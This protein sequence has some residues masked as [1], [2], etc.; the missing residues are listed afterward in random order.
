MAQ[1][2][3]TFPI[4]DNYGPF[5]QFSQ[6]GPVFFDSQ[7][8][9][10]QLNHSVPMYSPVQHYSEQ[11][12]VP[13]F[14]RHS[15]QSPVI[16][17]SPAQHVDPV[18]EQ[19]HHPYNADCYR[20]THPPPLPD[21]G[22]VSHQMNMGESGP[23]SRPQSNYLPMTPTPSQS[24]QNDNEPG[25]DN[26]QQFNDRETAP[27]RR[28]C[29]DCHAT[30]DND[31]KVKYVAPLL[32]HSNL[33]TLNRKCRERHAKRFLCQFPDCPRAEP[34]NGFANENERD[35]H[36]IAKHAQYEVG[37]FYYRCAEEDSCSYNRS[38]HPHTRKDNFTQHLKKIHH[39]RGDAVTRAVK[40]GENVFTEDYIQAIKEQDAQAQDRAAANDPP[41][42]KPIGNATIPSP[43]DLR[44][45]RRRQRPRTTRTASDQVSNASSSLSVG[46]RSKKRTRA[47]TEHVSFQ[48]SLSG[49]LPDASLWSAP[50]GPPRPT[51][52][53]SA[54]TV[55]QG[56]CSRQDD[57]FN[58]TPTTSISPSL[59]TVTPSINTARDLQQTGA[60][61]L[62][63][64]QRR[65]RPG[66]DL[67]LEAEIKSAGA[68]RNRGTL[69]GP[70]PGSQPPTELEEKIFTTLSSLGVHKANGPAF[71]VVPT[72]GFEDQYGTP[73]PQPPSV[74]S[75]SAQTSPGNYHCDVC[76]KSSLTQSRLTKHH[77]RHTRDFVCLWDD[78][79]M[80]RNSGAI[81][82]ARVDDLG[83]SRTGSKN[84][85]QRHLQ[86]HYK[87][88]D[89]PGGWKCLGHDIAGMLQKCF[90]VHY[91]TPEH[92]VQEIV[93]EHLYASGMSPLHV[94]AYMDR[95]YL[96]PSFEGAFWCGFCDDVKESPPLNEE[97][98]MLNET[99]LKKRYCD[100]RMNHIL[101]HLLT[102]KL[103]PGEWRY[104]NG[105]GRSKLELDIERLRAN[106]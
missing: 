95:C 65:S 46:R 44:T 3:R 102:E 12:F 6:T 101:V 73:T 31:S 103:D 51:Y 23:Y 21:S 88:N 19:I 52:P 38:T 79:R 32:L 26:L 2:P 71:S 82:P 11:F 77:K 66:F 85:H 36:A 1:Q 106:R 34:H 86:T 9:S 59:L 67:K 83:W 76:G 55:I 54:P 105:E 35:R 90:T 37:Q 62:A 20:E 70:P 4:L 81:D 39:L 100:E 72:T 10:Y 15:Q 99:Q 28:Q 93:R 13:T 89:W 24:C 25:Q 69:M 56:G 61:H 7:Q 8:P 78:C 43:S 48:H 40:A 29:P 64:P 92:G 87:K 91:G 75:S 96:P 33:L 5:N 45:D 58:T 97:E 17:W 80:N 60:Q 42:T 27:A 49:L 53:P 63:L 30:Y 22:Y 94:D 47:Q 50:A 14:Y 57:K 68:S 18:P 74:I 16:P 41:R 104:I 98:E 84:D